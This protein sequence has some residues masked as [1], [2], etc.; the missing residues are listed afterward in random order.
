MSHCYVRNALAMVFG[1]VLAGGCQMTGGA[2]APEPKPTGPDVTL[3]E[4][5]TSYTLAN[6][7]VT[8]VVAKAT[9]DLTSLQYKGL[10]TIY[11]NEQRVVGANFT[12]NASQGTGVVTKV[13]ID[14]K[15]TGGDRA[16]VSVKG[17]NITALNTDMEFRF[18]MGRGDSGIYTY[19]IYDH[20]ADYPAR[21]WGESRWVARVA[22]FFNWTGEDHGRELVMREV[23]QEMNGIRYTFAGSWF[24]HRS[25]GWAS[26]SKQVG[27]WL[28]NPSVE[29]VG[30]GPIKTDFLTHR[31]TNAAAPPCILLFCKANHF[32]GSNVTL[33]AGEHWTRIIGPFFLYVNSGPDPLSM[34]K[35]AEAKA[36]RETA[37][38]PYDWVNGADYVKADQ[39]TTVKGQLVLSDPIEPKAK[40]SNIRIGLAHPPYAP[41][42]VPPAAGR[43]G[44]GRG[45]ATAPDG[46]VARGGRGGN[47]PA[48]PPP[49]PREITWRGDAKYYQFWTRAADNGSFSIPDVIP[50][51]YTL[52]A[53]ADG[54]LGEYS[55]AD[56]TV[57][58]GKPVDLGKL[59]WTPVRHGKQLW[60][61]G[62]AD[63]NARE[64]TYGNKYFEYESQSEYAKMFPND[65]NFII[66]KS[67]VSK[68]W[69]YSQIPHA[70]EENAAP[71]AGGRGGLGGRGGGPSGRATPYA[72]HFQMPAGAKGKATLRVATCGGGARQVD[73][74]VNGQP[75]GTIPGPGGGDVI[76]RHG[77]QGPWSEHDVE[78]DASLLKQGEN[79]LTLTVPAGP[80]SSGVL[81]DYVRLELDDKAAAK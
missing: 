27:F 63:F 74:T 10:E 28:I 16:E 78:F 49:G 70:E 41:P 46:A 61:I 65:V 26:P 50:G 20:P 13:T 23:P 38:W 69:F 56:I 57:A 39:R 19:C 55:K 3:T 72:I 37:K 53:V 35:D 42:T 1:L 9:G 62:T 64:F 4:D 7:T 33:G 67:D 66:G 81:Y 79:V 22:D 43:G 31:D 14:P 48:G 8:A 17:I 51:E 80:I 58:A 44:R 36:A 32:G 73:V 54:V 68:D 11:R 6:G 75:A 47:A 21:S 52:Y 18:C 77:I 45:P 24:D 5:D 12:Q 40:M 30:D 25:Y 76:T 59:A 60:E 34:W 71:A 29:Y 2:A 15:T